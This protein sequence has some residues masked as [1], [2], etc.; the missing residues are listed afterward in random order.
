MTPYNN[1]A[2]LL[3]RMATLPQYRLR[4]PT[5]EERMVLVSVGTGSAPSIDGS[6]AAPDPYL[7]STVPQ[8]PGAL[9]S[10]AKVDQD[11]NCR[12]VGRC[13]AGARIDRE[14]QDLI[15]LDHQESLVPLSEP[16][17]RAFLYARYDADISSEGLAAL[18]LPH[19]DVK[20]VQQ[21]DAVDAVEDLKAI[22][23]A[24]AEKVD[25]A[26]FGKLIA[27]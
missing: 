18:G 9:M 21:M 25:L 12:I 13:V 7:L 17:G 20:R 11:I 2:F 23:R 3:F 14:L 22:G 27:K 4:W 16:L 24:V 10:G 19:V 8:L 15:P 1:P 26:A 5:G 6:I